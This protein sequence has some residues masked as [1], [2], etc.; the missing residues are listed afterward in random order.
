M[1]TFALT[2]SRIETGRFSSRERCLKGDT[3]LG[4]T[5]RSRATSFESRAELSLKLFRSGFA[6]SNPCSGALIR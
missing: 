3:T 1:R 5:L 4:S 6:S 2:K